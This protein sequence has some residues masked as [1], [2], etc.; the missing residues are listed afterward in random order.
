MISW[1]GIVYDRKVVDKRFMCRHNCAIESPQERIMTDER[2]ELSQRDIEFF[3]V[4]FVVL[5]AWA[6]VVA[7]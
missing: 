4:L 7:I 5:L 6:A 1:D 3:A 2:K